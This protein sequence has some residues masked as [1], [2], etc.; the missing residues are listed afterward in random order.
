MDTTFFENTFTIEN[1]RDILQNYR[2]FG[3]FLGI[4]LPLLESFLPVLPL[5]LFVAANAAVYGPFLG[6]LFS[7]IGTCLGAIIVFWFFR[8]FAKR[9]LKRWLEKSSKVQHTL[10]W[11]E[12]HGFGPLFLLLCFPFTPSSLVNVAA[13]VSELRFRSFFMAVMLGKM[14]MVAMISYIGHD[15]IGLIQ[16]PLKVLGIAIVVVILW[17]GGK[18]ME[19]RL[20][21]SG[22]HGR[23]QR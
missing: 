5:I 14:I 19:V 21:K 2:S 8:S 4:L 12:K 1:V 23:E 16:E 20:E 13:G 17:I 10:N 18:W 7:W 9:R 22:D 11:I 6:F 3:P 15:W